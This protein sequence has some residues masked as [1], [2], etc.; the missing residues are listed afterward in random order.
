MTGSPRASRAART[1]AAGLAALGWAMAPPALAQEAQAAGPAA[2]AQRVLTLAPHATEMVFA[3]GGGERIVGTVRYSDHPPAASRLP[4]VGDVWQIDLESLL[5]LRPDLIVAW[6][7]GPVLPLQPVLSGA[8]IP[9]FFAA[10][11]S[12]ADI[13][14]DIEKLGSLMGTRDVADAAAR[15]LRERLAALEARYRDREPV[16]VFVQAGTHPLYTL[17]D[18]HIVGVALRRCGA[19]NIFDRAGPIAPMVDIEAVI[20]AAPQAI[21]VGVTTGKAEAAAYWQR[22]A[23]ALPAVQKGH[24]FALDADTLYRPGPRLV[25]AAEAM[26][27]LIDEVR[28]DAGQGQAP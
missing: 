28:Q 21:L 27:E 8:D 11:A 18:A 23:A 19:R 24:V 17:T 25:D 13:A 7:P 15:Q 6:L 12:L 22:Y 26:C 10:P 14:A 5:A 4:R 16:T 2:P 3:A 9:V 20:A 1:L